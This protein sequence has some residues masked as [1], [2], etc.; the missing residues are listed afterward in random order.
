MRWTDHLYRGV[1]PGVF[2]CVYVCVFV[3]CVIKNLQKHVSVTVDVFETSGDVLVVASTVPA[4]LSPHPFTSP[5]SAVRDVV[6][7]VLYTV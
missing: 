2:V 4:N 3:W 7:V 6:T 5:Q 1:L